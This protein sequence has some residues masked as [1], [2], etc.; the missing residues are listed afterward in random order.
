MAYPPNPGAPTPTPTPRPVAP[1]PTG[2]SPADYMQTCLND[3]S[4]EDKSEMVPI[5]DVQSEYARILAVMRAA[6]L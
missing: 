3:I 4:T 5:T 6:E 1:L 2:V